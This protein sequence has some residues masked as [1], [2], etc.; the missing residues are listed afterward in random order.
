[1]QGVQECA[2]QDKQG[3]WQ[4]GCSSVLPRVTSEGVPVW[5]QGA[6]GPGRSTNSSCRSVSHSA[7]QGVLGWLMLL[8]SQ[9]VRFRLLR[10]GIGMDRV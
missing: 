1:M 10:Q 5:V 4:G 8:P 7:A 2:V 6:G 9:V 3:K